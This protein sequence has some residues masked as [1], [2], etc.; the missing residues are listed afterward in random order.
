MKVLPVIGWQKE[1]KGFWQQFKKLNVKEEYD[2]P[3]KILELGGDG[4]LLGAQR[5]YYK[6]NKPFIGVGFGSVNFLLNRSI[7]TPTDLYEKLE[8]NEWVDF[9]AQAIE[10]DIITKSG[11]QKGIAFNDIY[12]KAV[13]PTGTITLKLNTHEYSDLEVKGDGLILATPQ[14]S[15]AYSRNAGGTILPLG[16]KLWCLTGICTQNKLGV[17]VAQQEVQ[18]DVVCGEA[19]LITDNKIFEQVESVR[20]MPS[21]FKTVIGFDTNENFEQRRNE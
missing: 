8:K 2:N 12:L 5:D 6:L 13:D 16:S 17:V 3:D 4:A 7:D 1:A 11:T 9:L 21:N 15:T 18:I 19:V 20:I 10:A 14:G